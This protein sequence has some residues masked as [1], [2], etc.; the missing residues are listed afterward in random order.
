LRCGL[1]YSNS[2]QSYWIT[3]RAEWRLLIELNLKRPVNCQLMIACQIVKNSKN[4][5]NN[6]AKDSSD[7]TDLYAYR[8]LNSFKE[9]G[10]IDGK[11][12]TKENMGAHHSFGGVK[13][14]SC[15]V[16]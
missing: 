2:H 3:G 7:L 6:T 5:A 14:Q 8:V 15:K 10:A 9:E 13:N 11:Q 12:L 16:Y 1:T 4:S